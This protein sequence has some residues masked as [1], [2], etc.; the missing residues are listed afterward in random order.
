MAQQGFEEDLLRRWFPANA[1][2]TL[3]PFN[4]NDIR[5]VADVL[6]RCARERWSRVP[7]LYSILRKIGQLDTIDSFIDSDITD[8][9]FPFTKN[10]LPEALCDHSARLRF[11]ELQHLVYNTEALRLE[12][13]ARHG[14]FSDPTEVPLK[15]VGELGKGGYGY[16]DRVVSTISHQ[17]YARK[18]I[19]RGRTFKQNKQVLRDFTKE[20]SNLKRLCHK[21]LVELVGSYTDKRFVALIML[22]VADTNLQ[23]FMERSDLEERARSFLRPFFGCLTSALSYLHDN[24]IRH[25]DIKP[26]NILIKNDQV[27]FTD[28]GTSLDWSGRDNSVTETASPTTPRYCAP[29]VM[30]YVERNTASD[31]WSFGCVFLEM[32]TVLKHRTLKDLRT[33]MMTQGTGV[34]GYH[35]NLEAIAS[36]IA[37]LQQLPGP[38]SDLLPVDWILNMLQEKPVARWNIHTLDNRIGEAS[39]ESS[40][41]HTFKGL[42]CLELEDETSE[43]SRLSDED[44]ESS[45]APLPRSQNTSSCTELKPNQADLIHGQAVV[46]DMFTNLVASKASEGFN[47]SPCP[48][49]LCSELE[50]LPS[51]SKNFERGA[52]EL[53]CEAADEAGRSSDQANGKIKMPV[54]T[55]CLLPGF[56]PSISDGR[57]NLSNNGVPSSAKSS[58]SS[59]DESCASA[60]PYQ[61]LSRDSVSLPGIQ[62]ESTQAT[63]NQILCLR[64]SARSVDEHDADSKVSSPVAIKRMEAKIITNCSAT[65]FPM[66][67]PERKAA[68]DFDRHARDCSDCYNPL[69]IYLGNR[70]LCEEGRAYASLLLEHVMERRH[71]LPDMKS[72]KRDVGGRKHKSHSAKT[73]LE[74]PNQWQTH[75][76][77][78]TTIPGKVEPLLTPCTT[79]KP[80]PSAAG[81]Y[82][83]SNPRRLWQDYQPPCETPEYVPIYEPEPASSRPRRATTSSK[84]GAS[85][86]PSR[87]LRDPGVSAKKIGDNGFIVEFGEANSSLLPSGPASR[88]AIPSRRHEENSSI[89]TEQGHYPLPQAAGVDSAE[90]SSDAGSSSDADSE[91]SWDYIDEDN[92]PDTQ[93]DTRTEPAFST[94]ATC[95]YES[96]DEEIVRQPYPLMNPFAYDPQQRLSPWRQEQAPLGPG[97]NQYGAVPASLLSRTQLPQKPQ[98]PQSQR[99]HSIPSRVEREETQSEETQSEDNSDASMVAQPSRPTPHPHRTTPN[100][101]P[102][103]KQT[104]D[105]PTPSLNT[106]QTNDHEYQPDHATPGAARS[107]YFSKGGGGKGFNFS[108]ADDIFGEFMRSSGGGDE[109]LNTLQT[110]GHEYQSNHAMPGAARSFHFSTTGGGGKG[111]NFSNAD[112]I[113]GEFMR[114]NGGGDDFGGFGMGGMPGGMGG[115]G[116]G[117]GRA[118]DQGSVHAREVKPLHKKRDKTIQAREGGLEI[119]RVPKQNRTRPKGD[120]NS[121]DDSNLA[122]RSVGDSSRVKTTGRKST[123]G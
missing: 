24:R 31:I 75:V 3:T 46:G 32:W 122:P 47:E 80:T 110:N 61:S 22:P 117:D 25:K 120:R 73:E 114:S 40:A 37:L 108:N 89:T 88:G 33:H 12:R 4:E 59:G 66:S 96:Q 107:F 38:S 70:R 62:S 111:F 49:G 14:H 50:G 21:H 36:W 83:A 28:F 82:A 87:P 13:R 103:Y 85:N 112:D 60:P 11:L 63:N 118:S 52:K 105:K 104:W 90:S 99:K 91:D 102:L 95:G 78:L 86:K 69:G 45:I 97:T 64:N 109:S 10:T 101:K 26:S 48:P 57:I 39:F 7:R 41:Q 27:Y 35:S 123:W 42:C 44:L 15:K 17:E 56:D 19:P 20:L 18:L 113:F 5:E 1:E 16:V 84:Q 92:S 72:P 74:E 43:D 65:V 100:D 9:Y 81:L 8:V 94:A 58:P 79:F 116:G 77:C 98:R 106:L 53:A 93:N 54:Q 55:S 30:A 29:E 51:T 71:Q 6:T 68:C 76:N 121:A 2:K 34:G 119:R 67:E 23:S 115:M